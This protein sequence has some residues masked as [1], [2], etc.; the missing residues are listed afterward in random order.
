MIDRVRSM[1]WKVMKRCRSVDDYL[2]CCSCESIF[3][4]DLLLLQPTASLGWVYIG[5]TGATTLGLR[6]LSA[7]YVM[8]SLLCY[9]Y[10]VDRKIKIITI[11][12]FIIVV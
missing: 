1:I 11:A 10:I 9:C 7:E 12:T 2:W 5:A 8:L 4:V 6:H 3:V